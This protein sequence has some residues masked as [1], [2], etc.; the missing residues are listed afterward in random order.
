MFRFPPLTP[1]VKTLLVV[2]LGTYV[3]QLISDVW[4]G[5]ELFALLALD[6]RAGATVRLVWQVATFP[7]AT[8]PGPAGVM[9]FLISSLFFWLIVSPFEQTFGRAR[10]IQVLLFG[11]VG[12]LLPA[13]AVGLFFGGVLYGFGSLTLAAFMAWAWAMRL[14]RQEANFFGVM[15]MSPTQMMLVV[16]GLVLLNFLAS[17]N[18][19]LLAADLGATGGGILF[20][21]WISKPPAAKRER[22]KSGGR[23]RKNDLGLKVIQGG[24]DDAPPKWLN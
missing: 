11:A 5:G 19:V 10:T 22:K 15:P 6:M 24:K 1:T 21:E 7:F 12:A 2:F 8:P 3:A 23:R 16:L 18:F 9:P 13:L 17:Q 20:T 14:T 4:L